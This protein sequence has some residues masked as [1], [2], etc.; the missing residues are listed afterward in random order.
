MQSEC[1][2]ECAISCISCR[3]NAAKYN[4]AL[5]SRA[6]AAEQLNISESSLRDYETG[7]TPIPVDMVVRMA[8]LYGA[9]ELQISYCKHD[10]PIGKY[11]ARN[12]SDEVKDI[13]KVTCSILYH[14][15]EAETQEAFKKLLAI[16]S[17]GK[18]TDEEKIQLHQ[19]VSILE[20]V[21]ADVNSLRLLMDKRGGRDGDG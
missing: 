8:D 11:I 19:V 1:I 18:V 21:T 16:A 7:F 20:A 10:C 14:I 12:F 6:G 2:K 13:E 4:D 3:K 9:P 17:D 15:Q 5:N